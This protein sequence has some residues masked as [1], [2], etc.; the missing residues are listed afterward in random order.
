M[1]KTGVVRYIPEK[2]D[3]QVPRR[4]RVNKRTGAYEIFLTKKKVAVLMYLGR[5]LL[6]DGYNVNYRDIADNCGF[7]T[8]SGA[9]YAVRWLG[10]VGLVTTDAR[11]ARSVA[12]TPQGEKVFR[13]WQRRE[14][15]VK[16]Q[17]LGYARARKARL[18]QK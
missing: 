7:L 3:K 11:R 17:N 14:Q 2:E 15:V 1:E 10:E 6:D 5:K 18:K 12:M 13:E 16:K 4:A 8:P 9:L